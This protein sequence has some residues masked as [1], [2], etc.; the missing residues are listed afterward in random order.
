MKLSQDHGGNLLINGKRVGELI[1]GLFRVTTDSL[2][3]WRVDSKERF[4]GMMKEHGLEKEARAI[5]AK[6]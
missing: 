3:F 4:L 1:N 2:E 6:A 5:L